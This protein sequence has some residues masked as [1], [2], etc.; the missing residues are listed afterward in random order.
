MYKARMSDNEEFKPKVKKAT[1]KQMSALAKGQAVLKAKREALAKERDEHAEKVN[2]GEI[3][4][5]VPAP[6]FVPKPKKEAVLAPRPVTQEERK[7]NTMRARIA[8]DEVKSDLAAI[9]AEL[10]SLKTTKEVIVEK[11]VDRIVEKPVDR[12]VERI[13]TGSELLNQIFKLK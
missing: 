4:P 6:K 5:D 3:P 13:V 10:A 12:V 1:E 11:P 9:R 8:T 2:K 7:R